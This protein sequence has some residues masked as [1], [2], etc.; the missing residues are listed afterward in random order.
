MSLSR[1][2]EFN[3]N[4]FR[5]IKESSKNLFSTL[6]DSSARTCQFQLDAVRPSFYS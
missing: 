6:T 3:R 4:K 2:K 5:V 1:I